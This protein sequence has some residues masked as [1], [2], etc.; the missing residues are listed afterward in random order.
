MTDETHISGGKFLIRVLLSDA[1]LAL[2]DISLGF[3]WSLIAFGN[4]GDF[5]SSSA[6]MGRLHPNFEPNLYSFLPRNF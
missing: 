3:I 1:L 4:G 6:F 5:V 2:S